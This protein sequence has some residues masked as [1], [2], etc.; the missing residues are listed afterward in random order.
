[1]SDSDQNIEV[2]VNSLFKGNQ[3][4]AFVYQRYTDVRLVGTPPESIG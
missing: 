4:L 1:M 3:F 2:R